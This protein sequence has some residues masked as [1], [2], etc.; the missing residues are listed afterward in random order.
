MS[1]SGDEHRYVMRRRADK[2]LSK[3]PEST[4]DRI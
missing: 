3:L 4:D 1:E 2:Q